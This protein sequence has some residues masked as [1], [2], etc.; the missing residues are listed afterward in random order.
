[1]T[2][3]IGVIIGP[4]LGGLLS[5][6]A[7]SYPD[8]FGNIGFFKRF[9]YATPNILSG[10]FLFTAGMAVWLGLEEVCLNST[11]RTFRSPPSMPTA[12][13][14]KQ[15]LDSLRDSPPDL[16]TRIGHKLAAFFGRYFSRSPGRGRYVALHSRDNSTELEDPLTPIAPKKPHR[17]PRYTTRLPFRRIFTRNVTFTFI[18]HF[19][20]AFHIGTFNSL[21]NIFLSTPVYDPKNPPPSLPHPQ[22][23]FRFTGGL[24][25]PP[26][27]VGMA[28]AILGCIGIFLQIVLYPPMSARLGT[29]RAW[30]LCFLLFPI[31][32][33]LVPYLSVVPSSES[34][35]PPSPKGGIAIWLSICG[36]LFLQVLGRTFALPSQTILVNN[37]TPH[38]SVL[39]TVH[40]LGQ[41]VSSAARTIGPMAGGTLY[42][43]GLNNGIVGAVFWGLS[44][45]AICGVIASWFVREGD[46][47]EIWLEGDVEDEEEPQD[48]PIGEQRPAAV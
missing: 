48:A 41:S 44:G 26:A 43:L 19:F 34:A 9:P 24:G 18:T 20:M 1:M 14:G 11:F 28:M 17:G 27:S 45:I 36:V 29:I 21:W 33:F 5:D 32:Y 2:F 42:G 10:L 13:L 47:H 4:I 46:G 3:N 40:G 37:C 39:G 35:P 15:T 6:P 7:G 38:P 31:T 25:L 12:N 30:R 16:G 22:L 8:L 23:P